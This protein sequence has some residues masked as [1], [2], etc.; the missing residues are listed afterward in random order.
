VQHCVAGDTT[1]GTGDPAQTRVSSD[2]T[3]TTANRQGPLGGNALDLTAKDVPFFLTLASDVTAP[4]T[5]HQ[6]RTD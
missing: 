4:V 1:L 2:I 3:S 6:Q 5:A